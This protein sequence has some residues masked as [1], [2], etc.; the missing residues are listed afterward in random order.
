MSNPIKVLAKNAHHALLAA[1]LAA[2]VVLARL[3]SNLSYFVGQ[4]GEGAL[5]NITLL[6][7]F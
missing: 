1:A 4:R 3:A 6:P 7:A 2:A 5:S